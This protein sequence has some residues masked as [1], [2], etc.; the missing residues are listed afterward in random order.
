[1]R[2][3]YNH[4][5]KSVTLVMVSKPVPVVDIQFDADEGT[6][7]LLCEPYAEG[8]VPLKKTDPV[9]FQINLNITHYNFI[10][11]LALLL[12][13]PLVSW[14]RLMTFIIIGGIILGMTQVFHLYN[15]VR[16]YYFQTQEKGGY[17]KAQKFSVNSPRFQEYKKL[18]VKI[19]VFRA[20][21]GLM[22]QAGSMIMPALIW[23]I[24]ASQW[25]LMALQPIRRPE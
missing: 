12:A 6:L 20:M 24:Y 19:A 8:P 14:K 3:P 10:P 1:M 16:Y 23:M 5:L 13:S 11:F 2:I 4:L 17:F 21:Y 25:I 22:E 18:K 9:A 7:S 15:G